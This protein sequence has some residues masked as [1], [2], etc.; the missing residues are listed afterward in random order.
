MCSSGAIISVSGGSNGV[1]SSSVS[2]SSTGSC[3]SSGI[4][5]GNSGSNGSSSHSGSFISVSS[6]VIVGSYLR[7]LRVGLI[8]FHLKSYGSVM[9][10]FA[11]SM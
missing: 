8:G 7:Y 5:S 9:S 1:S 10:D 11:Y 4:C 3:G 2:G 6:C